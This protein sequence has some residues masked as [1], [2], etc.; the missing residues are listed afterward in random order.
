MFCQIGVQQLISMFDLMPDTLFWIKDRNSRMLHV[1]APLQQHLGITDAQ[2]VVGM[3]DFDFAPKHIAKQFVS[4]DQ[5]VMDGSTI[6]NRLEINVAN[7]GE[8]AWYL[9][10]RRPLFDDNQNVI[11]TYGVSRRVQQTTATLNGMEAIKAPLDYIKR[12]YMLDFSITDLAKTA[13]LSVSALERR[14]KKYMA[15]TPKQ[16]INEVRLE[17]A[18]RLL[19]E[20]SLP[21]AVVGNESGFA[22]HSYFTRRF[23]AMFNDIPSVYRKNHLAQQ[24]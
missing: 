15:K 14:F 18:R 7:G 17:N 19:I 13:H 9:T 3:S 22:D 5:R 1:N 11:G 20:T 6:T 8:F 21:I 12:N 16:F 23:A 4:D 10:S 2:Q 24:Q